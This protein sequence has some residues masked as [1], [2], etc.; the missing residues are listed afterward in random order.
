MTENPSFSPPGKREKEGNKN[1]FK[2]RAAKSR[3][4]T[5]PD[6]GNQ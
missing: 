6:S 3:A 2:S 5:L 4:A 1:R